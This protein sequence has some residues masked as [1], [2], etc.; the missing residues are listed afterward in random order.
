MIC[1]IIDGKGGIIVKIR[2]RSLGLDRYV[3]GVIYDN[4]RVTRS[5]AGKVGFKYNTSAIVDAMNTRTIA[6]RVL[7]MNKHV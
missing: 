6:K 4:S 2:S 7:N 3:L 1:I 5:G